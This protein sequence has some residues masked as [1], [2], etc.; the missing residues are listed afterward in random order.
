ME[1]VKVIRKNGLTQWIEERNPRPAAA[2]QRARALPGEQRRVGQ[3]VGVPVCRPGGRERRSGGHPAGDQAATG[4]RG[5]DQGEQAGQEP[6][7]QPGLGPVQG[8][9]ETDEA[10]DDQA[11]VRVGQGASQGQTQR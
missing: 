2:Y 4:E 11:P 8:E 3:A 7:R 10:R 6:P 1:L 5:Q 9:G